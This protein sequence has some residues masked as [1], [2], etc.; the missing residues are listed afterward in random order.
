MKIKIVQ[1]VNSEYYIGE[2]KNYS[3]NKNWTVNSLGKNEY[4]RRKKNWNKK[5][6]K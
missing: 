2:W 3:E 4:D 1:F 6:S 5:H